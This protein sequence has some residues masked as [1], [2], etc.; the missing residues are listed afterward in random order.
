MDRVRH[1][2]VGSDRGEKRA[3]SA[4]TWR[5]MAWEHEARYSQW[6]L[7]GGMTYETRRFA[8]AI[9]YSLFVRIKAQLRY[10]SKP[11]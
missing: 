10:V 6:V 8:S 3:N 4:E 1:I 11:L 7:G 9:S 5:S 2:V